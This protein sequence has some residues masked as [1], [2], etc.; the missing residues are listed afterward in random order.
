MAG[1][2]TK[3]ANG[4]AE[5]DELSN[6]KDFKKALPVTGQPVGSNRRALDVMALGVY[7]VSADNVIEAGSDDNI[8]K[9]TSHGARVGDV[10]R[11]ESSANN[12]QE[13]EVH[14]DEIVDA[15][16]FK[17][18]CI[19]SGLLVA[20]DE[21]TLLRPVSQRF[22]EDGASLATVTPAP[23][24]FLYN[25]DV[26]QVVEDT[27]TPG[28]NTPLPVKLT[29]V[30][31]DINITAGDLNVQLSDVGVNADKTRVGDGSG[32]YLGINASTEALTHDADTLAKLIE[33]ETI[34]QAS[35]DELEV[36]AVSIGE[37]VDTSEP[38]PTQPASVISALKGV[39]ENL[40]L[41]IEQLELISGA[42]G[43]GEATE[44]TLLD[45]LAA[46]GAQATLVQT[47]P[48]SAASL[49]LPSGAS[50]ATLQTD[51]NTLLTDIKT[52]TTDASTATLQNAGNASLSTIAT[53]N[54][55]VADAAVTNPGASGSVIALLKG[56]LTLITSTNTKLDTIDANSS[57]ALNSTT[58]NTV[59]T[60]TLISAPASAIG[61]IIQNS[62]NSESDIRF[63]ASGVTPTSLVGFRLGP[64]QSTSYMPAGSIRTI[65]VDGGAIDVCVLWF[66]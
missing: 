59:V 47:Q 54:G 62:T 10:F 3:S 29:S 24:A 58:N 1:L 5:S 13:F 16:H 31:G 32:N 20:G 39:N 17:L 23:L 43:G 45:V 46:I 12:I 51:G 21:F 57:A 61:M 41:A 64:G 28:N 56:L 34:N 60:N 63:T 6:Q 26:T 40:L 25:G 30:T 4:K 27:V 49:P 65:S 48:V 55:A 14:I 7:T 15:D 8:V 35:L 2:T 33:I 52:N 37:S 36:I 66:V 19:L 50:N 42:S 11:L 38:D 18:A 53:N 22:T 44:N 9:C